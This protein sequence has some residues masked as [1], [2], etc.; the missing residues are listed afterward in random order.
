MQGP[1][2]RALRP[3]GG[4]VVAAGDDHGAGTDG[5]AFEGT[6]FVEA[7]GIG[8]YGGAVRS[9]RIAWRERSSKPRRNE[10]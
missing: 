9:G 3:R 7:G 10:R 6:G 5:L 4:A 8:V 2:P 1:T